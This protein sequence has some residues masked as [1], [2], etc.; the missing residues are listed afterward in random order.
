MQINGKNS[1]LT[2]G[3]AAEPQAAEAL[4]NERQEAYCRQVVAVL[5]QGEE[6]QT[7]ADLDQV[8]CP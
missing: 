8:P 1:K 7:P 5:V 2:L 6:E 4:V 3:S